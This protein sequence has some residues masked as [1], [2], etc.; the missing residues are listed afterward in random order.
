[1]TQ[2]ISMEEIP[3]SSL[4]V[5]RK[6]GIITVL[7]FTGNHMWW[8]PLCYSGTSYILSRKVTIVQYV[9][10]AQ[11]TT[12]ASQRVLAARHWEETLSSLASYAASESVVLGS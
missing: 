7:P 6:G 12:I 9:Q 4:S 10:S 2:R 8:D 11:L 5:R 1:M 3:C